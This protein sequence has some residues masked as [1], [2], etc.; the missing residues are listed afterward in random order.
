ME[1]ETLAPTAA[2]ETPG[3]FRNNSLD[4]TPEKKWELFSIIDMS[5]IHFS[6]H[7][8]QSGFIYFY[9]IFFSE[10]QD[11]RLGTYYSSETNHLKFPSF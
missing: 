4:L 6:S 1:R 11:R 8:A 3:E 7:I 10:Y 9:F 5:E 2:A